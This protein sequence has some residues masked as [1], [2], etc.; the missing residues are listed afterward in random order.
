VD[1]A[2]AWI[3]R[4]PLEKTFMANDRDDLL[5]AI[6]RKQNDSKRLIETTQRVFKRDRNVDS[7]EVLLSAVGKEKRAG[8][9]ETEAKAIL[10]ASKFD[11]GDA[12]FLVETG[13]IDDAETYIIAHAKELDGHF[14]TGLL[15]L[16]KAML[17]HDRLVAASVIYRALLD[18]ILARAKS[19]NYHH[20][21]SYLKK[22]DSLAPK[23]RD[24]KEVD[25]HSLYLT[26]LR[27][28]HKL[29]SSFWAQYNQ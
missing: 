13:R 19:K 8:I 26:N 17:K 16:A 27:Q 11:Q 5:I 2:L 7:L 14:Y 25:P 20:G 29:K 23:V 3:E 6:Y 28:K 24:W 12:G 9:L 18:S 21:V 10:K 1:T 15:E 4:V 22:L